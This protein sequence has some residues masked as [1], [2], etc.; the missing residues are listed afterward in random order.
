MRAVIAPG[1][2]LEHLEA[3]RNAHLRGLTDDGQTREVSGDRVILDRLVLPP[4]APKDAPHPAQVVAL[5]DAK[6]PAVAVVV[7]P[8]GDRDEV[9]A[10]SLRYA[11]DG[12]VV[13]ANGHVVATIDTKARA[14][15]PDSNVSK[16]AQG[17]V[18]ITAGE[19]R[20]DLA[21]DASKAPAGRKLLKVDAGG[22]VVVDGTID[23]VEGRQLT[24][25][26]VTGVAEVRGERQT[27]RVVYAAESSRYPS[28]L[29]ADVIRAQFDVS[30]DPEK[31][32]KLQRVVCPEGGRIIRYVDAPDAAT[33]KPAPGST[34]R[35]IQI[36]SKG[37]MEST[38]TE[39]T[40][41]DDVV[42]GM[43]TLSK[44]GEWTDDPMMFKGQRVRATFDADA[45][46]PTRDRLR[47]LD[48]VGDHEHQVIVDR[49]DFFGRA[50]RVELD[51]PAGTIRLST[52]GGTDVY[53]RQIA[54]GRQM[55]YDSV[56]YHYETREWTDEV[57]GR[58]LEPARGPKAEK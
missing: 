24:Y 35:R 32:G 18:R 25:D 52:V 15:E 23:R 57:R 38:R 20:V 44:S 42:A 8:S 47:Y 54:S 34:P 58:E 50:D 36:E 26:A 28:L 21:P 19:A 16:V 31:K 48:A 53:V 27:A 29:L 12:S 5:G 46:G 6:R 56:V 11:Q 22:G 10:D 14:A 9:R 40:A 33:G 37:P 51:G 43:F 17:P 30:D 45:Q 41:R 49:S 3:N 39:A 2:Q 13:F 55:T 1:K 7:E 4:G